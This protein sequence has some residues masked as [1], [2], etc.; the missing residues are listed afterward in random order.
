M[1][2]IMDWLPGF[3]GGTAPDTKL[4][5]MGGRTADRLPGPAQPTRPAPAGAG[6]PLED[7]PFAGMPRNGPDTRPPAARGNITPPKNRAFLDKPLPGLHE[8]SSDTTD[9]DFDNRFQFLTGQPSI[10]GWGSYAMR[11]AQPLKGPGLADRQPTDYKP[12]DKIA[13]LLSYAVP[14]ASNDM[15]YTGTTPEGQP[16]RSLYVMGTDAQGN[17]IKMDQQQLE[18]AIKLGTAVRNEAQTGDKG[19]RY[20]SLFQPKTRSRISDPGGS[21]GDKN[22]VNFHGMVT[23]SGADSRRARAENAPVG[24]QVTPHLTPDVPGTMAHE[25]GHLLAQ[26][27]YGADANQWGPMSKSVG[28]TMPKEVQSSFAA[29]AAIRGQGGSKNFLDYV[30]RPSE[31]W[32]EAVRQYNQ[33][34]TEYKRSNPEAAKWMREINN[35]NPRLNQ[36]LTL[37][38]NEK[39]KGVP[40]TL[41]GMVG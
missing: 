34:P 7:D 30:N 32:A 16:F 35:K 40:G 33:N 38:E 27:G 14:G 36:F 11:P 24:L 22:D 18:N 19:I 20:Y 12:S 28:A 5:P 23:A 31:K 29:D 25:F 3:L 6:V 39:D 10:T 26:R 37:S 13:D 41:S 15:Y 8:L 21:L 17:D 2:S 9:R 1:A 4:P